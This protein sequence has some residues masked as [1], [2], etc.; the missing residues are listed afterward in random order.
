[1]NIRR[2]LA[3]LISTFLPLSDL[4]PWLSSVNGKS[5]VA[6]KKIISLIFDTAVMKFTVAKPVKEP[7]RAI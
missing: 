6:S 4:K 2:L 1:V 5:K 3:A 7:T